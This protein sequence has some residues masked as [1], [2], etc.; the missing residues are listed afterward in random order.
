MVSETDDADLDVHTTHYTNYGEKTKL[1][2]TERIEFN[3]EW[4]RC[5]TQPQISVYLRCD[6][7]AQKRKCFDVY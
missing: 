7:Q 6:T 3:R 4:S 5:L 2:I 1:D